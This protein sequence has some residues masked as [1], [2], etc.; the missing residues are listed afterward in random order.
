MGNFKRISLDYNIQNPDSA[1]YSTYAHNIVLE[2][3]SGVGL[4]SIIFL[5]FLVFLIRDILKSKL[6]IGEGALILAILISFTTDIT[7]AIPGL[8]WVLFMA[9]GTFQSNELLP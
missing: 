9:I 2:M 7:Y 4:F 6:R 1:A 8:I 3:I 5:I